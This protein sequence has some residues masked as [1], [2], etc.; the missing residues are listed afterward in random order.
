MTSAVAHAGP[1]NAE[2]LAEINLSVSG[3]Q[4]GA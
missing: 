1:T 4:T 3:D 2:E